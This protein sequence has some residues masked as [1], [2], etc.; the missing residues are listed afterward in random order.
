MVNVDVS[1]VRSVEKIYSDVLTEMDENNLTL[2]DEFNQLY[3]NWNDNRA[4]KMKSSFTLEKN[5]II[6]L[7][8]D[9]R[10]QY[11]IYQY[12]DKSYS[13]YGNKISCNLDNYTYI[14]DKI[15]IVIEQ[16]K[17][18]R[19]QYRDLGDISFYAKAYLIYDE[20]EVLDDLISHFINLKSEIKEKFKYVED[21]EKNITDLVDNNN[22]EVFVANNY[23]SEE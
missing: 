6:R 23:E 3:D 18:V 7:L 12:I 14:M 20:M 21:V 1:K 4:E 16:L 5:R 11:K 15:D 19:D 10:N 17:F 9:I 22:I 13:I 8:D 2:L